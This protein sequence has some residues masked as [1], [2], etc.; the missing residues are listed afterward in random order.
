MEKITVGC[1]K[2]RRAELSLGENIRIWQAL[3]A[4]TPQIKY[5]MP[6]AFKQAYCGLWEILIQEEFHATAS[7]A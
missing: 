2:H 6:H 7:Y 1:Q 3:A 5:L 4:R